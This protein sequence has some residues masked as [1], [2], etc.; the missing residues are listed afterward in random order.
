MVDTGAT[1]VAMNVSTAAKA[2]IRLKPTDFRHEV[3]TANGRTR[4]A[5]AVID[6]LEIGRIHVTNVEAVILDDDALRSTLIG[7]SFL[8]RLGKYQVE[9]HTLLLVQ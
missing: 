3:Q 8:R 5:S 6:S 9:N 7:M 2:G 1:L 4:A